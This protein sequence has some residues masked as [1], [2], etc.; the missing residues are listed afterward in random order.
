MGNETVWLLI[1]FQMDQLVLVQCMKALFRA[2]CDNFSHS[3][4]HLKPIFP[5]DILVKTIW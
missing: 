5:A 2:T 3:K 1:Y 4:M